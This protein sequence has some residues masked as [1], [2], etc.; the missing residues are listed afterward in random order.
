VV[1]LCLIYASGPVY[2]QMTIKKYQELK[3]KDALGD[4]WFQAYITGLGRG[5]LWMNAVL[6]SR[7]QPQA[8]CVPEH[9]TLNADNYIDVLNRELKRDSMP[10]A[11]PIEM[12][13]LGGLMRPFPCPETRR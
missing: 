5:F 6:A 9:L 1:V 2:G 12:E 13:L 4:V 10:D 3:A 8:S 7:G 11:M